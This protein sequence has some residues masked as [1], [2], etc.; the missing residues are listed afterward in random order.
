MQLEL[1]VSKYQQLRPRFGEIV[2]MKE[3]SVNSNGNINSPRQ[4]CTT[5]VLIRLDLMGH[6]PSNRYLIR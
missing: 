2:Q 6:V 5:L 3:R 1:N 4:A